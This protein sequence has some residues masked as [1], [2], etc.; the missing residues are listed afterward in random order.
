MRETTKE[1]SKQLKKA[2]DIYAP[3]SSSS[4]ELSDN[5]K[6]LI[7]ELAETKSVRVPFVGDFSSGKSTLLNALLDRNILPTAI[8]PETA[9]P[10]ELY[11]SPEE[12]MELYFNGVMVSEGKPSDIDN[13]KVRTGNLIKLYLDNPLLKHV[14]DKGILLVDMPGIDSGVEAHTSAI[15]EYLTDG[16]H[17]M[18]FGDVEKGT[19]TNS[20]LGFIKE[21]TQYKGVDFNAF[22][23]KAD[24]KSPDAVKG[25][26][27]SMEKAL[28]VRL[29]GERKVG[30]TSASMGRVEE[31]KETIDAI[32]VDAV[33]R[34]RFL[35]EVQIILDRM[36]IDLKTTE[37][38]LAG[39]LKNADKALDEIAAKKQEALDRLRNQNTDA[40]PLAGST[41]DIVKDVRNG[42]V[43]NS[44][45]IAT[46]IFTSKNNK[47]AVANAVIQ[48]VRP[49]LSNSL[50]REIEEYATAISTSVAAFSEDIEEILKNEGMIYDTANDFVNPEVATTV[51]STFLSTSLEKLIVKVAPYKSLTALLGILSKALGPLT[52]IIINFIPDIL[53]FFFGKSDSQK[54]NEIQAK[55]C[56]SAAGQISE[57]LRPTI[58]NIL[59]EQRALADRQVEEMIENESKRIDASIKDMI[60]MKQAEKAECEKKQYQVKEAVSMLSEIKNNL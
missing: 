4:S 40:Q 18:V 27:E 16:T 54:I 53:K 26:K 23:T 17:Y 34:N 38:L 12:R 48:V 31:V 19:F 57:A 6:Q 52:A 30:I 42:I 21:L 15:N 36:I 46:A 56:D 35:P 33:I 29:G 44:A 1:Y 14:S 41:D 25:V 9:V 47:D 55:I 32:D 22:L 5:A 10:Y 58:Q 24:K 37:G 28:S 39:D 45:T 49:I 13:L 60:V 8:T 11:Y 50:Q 3:L 51:L 43:S 59:S 7:K 20:A 2:I